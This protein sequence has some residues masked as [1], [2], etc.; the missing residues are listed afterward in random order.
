MG[1]DA[2][3]QPTVCT[4]ADHLPA[5]IIRSILDFF[6]LRTLSCVS[7]V[8]NIWHLQVVKARAAN[9]NGFLLVGHNLVV[10]SFYKSG[11]DAEVLLNRVSSTPVLFPSGKLTFVHTFIVVLI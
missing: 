1:A 2:S 10:G 4:E 3:K 7:G 5:E 9:T 11:Q 8:S 6:D